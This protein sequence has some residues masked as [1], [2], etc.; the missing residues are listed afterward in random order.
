MA[1]KPEDGDPLE[2]EPSCR[3]GQTSARRPPLTPK[4]PSRTRPLFSTPLLFCLA[5]LLCGCSLKP[6]Y[7][8]PALP[9][10]Q[11]YPEAGHDNGAAASLPSWTAFF[12]DPELKRLISRA[13]EQNRDLAVARRKIE[14]ARAF[15]GIRRA[16][17]LPGI[18][19]GA[20]A[21][22]SRTP[23]DLSV[24]G[25]AITGNLFEAGL[26]LASWEL[27]FWGRVGSLKEAALESYLSSIEA[28]RAVQVSLVAQVAQ[29]YLVERELSERVSLAKATIQSREESFRIA[30]RRF[31]V[32]SASKLDAVQAETLLNQ[33]RAELPALMRLRALNLN[34]LALLAGEA[35]SLAPLPLSAVEQDFIAAIAPGLPS[36]LLLNRP[37][38]MAAE[39]DLKAANA[40]IGA[41]RAA[42]FP[43]I[44]LTGS[45]GTASSEL[46][47][48]FAAGSG[49]WSFAPAIS[50]PIFQGGRN[51][52]NLGLA[53]AR[54]CE[55]VA[56]YERV[57]QRAFRDVADALAQRHWLAEQVE[58]Q[59]ATLAA[60]TE[61]TRLAR[62][63]Y[64]TGAATYLEVLDAERDRFVAQQALVQTRRALL[65]A[66][67]EL[68]AALGGGGDA[69]EG[70]PEKGASR[71]RAG[72]IPKGEAKP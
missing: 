58:A 52:A 61:R 64:D 34:A 24:T 14:E 42:F 55:A 43:A 62:L 46:S 22:R 21:E 17:Q 53:R 5:V 12:A 50:L 15:Y 29:S 2:P 30:R 9:V 19:A 44:A 33:A 23:A 60:Q 70:T 49:A 45:F 71:P 66:G 63:R 67:V 54:E 39:H 16:D 3:P 7:Q 8:R 13:L 40:A 28:R 4:A 72:G 48:L 47:G 35:V 59:R 65:S 27:D 68:Y 18:S 41:A 11:H 10:P 69:E 38:V 37:D 51:A 31:E 25:Q 1:Q 56:G 20:R 32:G 26:F 57:V 6:S 36:D